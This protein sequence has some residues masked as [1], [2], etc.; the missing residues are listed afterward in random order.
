LIHTDLENTPHPHANG[1]LVCHALR[2]TFTAIVFHT[3]HA[4]NERWV[5]KTITLFMELGQL[6]GNTT[7]IMS[8]IIRMFGHPC[9]VILFAKT[10]IAQHPE[11]L[12]TF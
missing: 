3:M 9:I 10:K 1:F 2:D 7:L 4:T 5:I 6:K 8:V 12:L 11:I